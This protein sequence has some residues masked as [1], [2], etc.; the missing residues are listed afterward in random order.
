MAEEY[1]WLVYM[2]G[3]NDLGKRDLDK[4][5]E[6]MRAGLT[7]HTVAAVIHIDR[8]KTET[9][10]T[11][12]RKGMR[13][14]KVIGVNQNAGDP[15]T[16]S[17]F[18]NETRNGAKHHVLCIWG[19]GYGWLAAAFDTAKDKPLADTR[20]A[21]MP[22]VRGLLKTSVEKA[23][24]EAGRDLLDARELRIGISGGR[25]RDKFAIIACD[26][27]YMAMLEVA[28][29]LRGEGDILV[30]S[31][32]EEDRAGW[33]YEHIFNNFTPGLKPDDAA[34]N[35]L[36]AYAPLAAAE[37]RATLSAIELKEISKVAKAVDELGGLL[38]PLIGQRDRFEAIQQARF[39][40][41]TFK[42]YHYIDL[43]HFAERLMVVF[44]DDEEVEDVVDAA[45]DVIKAIKD[46]VI[47]TRNGL[48][49]ANAHG[50][51][52]YLPNEP[53]DD[54]YQKLELTEHAP[55]WAEFVITYGANR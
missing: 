53:V 40:T 18:L 21:V 22:L 1:N 38:T 31:E 14:D 24:D 34:K 3:D 35:I 2:A 45:E 6:E 5:L 11:T 50:L 13:E 20:K 41:H 19:H 55:K 10:R 17:K 23:I 37:P 33:D 15:Q 16:L 48:E 47:G 42:M 44:G 32:E 4:D 52:V 51:A 36:D 30:A 9:T 29:E 49:A 7:S 25:G 27:C 28:F 26:A 54:N 12:L 46:A 43:G 39:E 8:L